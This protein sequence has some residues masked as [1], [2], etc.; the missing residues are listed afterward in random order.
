MTSIDSGVSFWL[1]YVADAGGVWEQSG[2]TVLS[3][4]PEELQK[5]HAQPEELAVT[6]DPD[7]AREDGA[8]LLSAGHPLLIGAAEYVLSTGDC[9]ALRLASTG[10]KQPSPEQLLD[11][12]RGQ[13]AADHGRIDLIG[14]PRPAVRQLLRVGALIT[15]A[16]SIDDQFQEQIECWIDVATHLPLAGPVVGELRNRIAGQDPDRAQQTAELDNLVPALAAAHELLEQLADDRE[17]E[18]APDVTQR[19]LAERQRVETYYGDALE[20]L[21]RRLQTAVPERAA[22]LNARLTSTGVERERRVAEIDDKFRPKRTAL[23]FRLQLVGVPVLRI[24]VDVRRGDRRYPWAF[25]WH[26]AARAFFAERC[27]H[28][29]GTAVLVAGK[30]RLGCRDCLSKPAAQPITQPMPHPSSTPRSGVCNLR[31]VPEQSAGPIGGTP[32]TA[33]NGPAPKRGNETSDLYPVLDIGVGYVPAAVRRVPTLSAAKI[34]SLGSKVV[35]NLWELTQNSDRRVQR[36]LAPDSPAATAV[37]LFGPGAARIVVDLDPNLQLESVSTSVGRQVPESGVFLVDGDV[38]RGRV[39]HP[40]QIVWTQVDGQPRICEFTRFAG[41]WWPRQPDSRWCRRR[42][43]GLFDLS[44]PVHPARI[45][46]DPVSLVIYRRGAAT[47]GL[48]IALRAL[49]AWWRIEDSP[50]PRPGENPDALAAAILR[51]V[52]YR[53]GQTGSYADVAAAM[54]VDEQRL[55]VFGELL[56]RPLK[57][58]ATTVW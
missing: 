40:F 18:L 23:P 15:Y 4:L 36:I 21:R 52:L 16:L 3:L 9:G 6:A 31:A 41:A 44:E 32:G 57:L 28:C 17:H 42:D 47:Y 54:R 20:S 49:T 51:A 53:A 55:R 56:K 12:A 39:R 46:L 38:G 5:R 29:R 25:D 22:T 8:T 48:P 2:D 1:H 26:P 10:A 50:G 7:A 45:E 33:H 14:G 35:I 11:H 58:T 27:P 37:R 13:F 43:A 30:D 19:H 24:D 34:Q